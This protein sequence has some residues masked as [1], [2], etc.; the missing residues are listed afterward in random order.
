VSVPADD[1]AWLEL[2]RSSMPPFWAVLAECTGGRVWRSD[3]I[4]A[5]IVPGSPKRSFFNSVLYE[6]PEAL[7]ASIGELEEVYAAGGV[8]AWTV[9]VPEADTVVAQ[10]LEA[11]GHRLDATPRAMAMPIGGL[12]APQ[13][14]PEL[15][16]REEPD[17]E[18]VSS[19]NEV[20]YGF[21]PGEFPVMQRDLSGLRTYLG[22]IGGETVACAGAFTH[23][24][25]CEIVF[26]AVLPEGRGRGISGRLTARAVADA[27]E[28]GLETTTL[29]ATK[30][31]Y[32]VY[33]N[34]GY[35]D[36]GELQM[37]ERR[38]PA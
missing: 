27:A 6:E 24:S 38:K 11:A 8:E 5:A 35:A 20:A 16:I 29:Q 10:A 7:I 22:S 36:H 37:W 30:L 13:P 2:V 15:E 26:V 25:D 4:T 3:G 1:A 33:V 18:L 19:L 32:P 12:R 31:G 9:W 14:D 21:A 23:G 28:Q 17:F 34:L